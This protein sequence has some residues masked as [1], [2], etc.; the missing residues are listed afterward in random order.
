[1]LLRPPSFLYSLYQGHSYRGAVRAKLPTWE[2]PGPQSRPELPELG[3]TKAPLEA[4]GVNPS[5]RRLSMPRHARWSSRM[6][7][8]RVMVLNTST[9]S[10]VQQQ[11]LILVCHMT[12]EGEP[13]ELLWS[14]ILCQYQ[15][16]MFT[17]TCNVVCRE[18]K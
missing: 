11:S 14:A 6:S 10:R 2:L 7:S 9:C 8:S 3:L 15:V 5:R 17:R 16:Q 18:L 13:C 1:M 12:G 4:E